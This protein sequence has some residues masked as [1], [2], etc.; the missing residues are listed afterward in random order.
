MTAP[1]SEAAKSAKE[2]E[3]EYVV[4]RR[5]DTPNADDWEKIGSYRGSAKQAIKQAAKLGEGD[6]GDRYKVGTFVAVPARSFRPV[7][8]TTRVETRVKLG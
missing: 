8:L 2:T 3:T 5:H 4:L 1:A 6:Q 7:T